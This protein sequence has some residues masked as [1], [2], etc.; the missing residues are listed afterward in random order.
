M[1]VELEWFEKYAMNRPYTWEKAPESPKAA[2]KITS[3]R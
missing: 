2:Q 3:Q 1:N